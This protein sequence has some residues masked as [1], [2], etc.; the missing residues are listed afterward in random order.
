MIIFTDTD[1]IGSFIIRKFTKSNWSHVAIEHNGM[2]IESLALYRN[3]H[4]KSTDCS[5]DNGASHQLNFLR[6]TRNRECPFCAHK[7]TVPKSQ[8]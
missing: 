5:S 3:N 7:N 1:L 2:V 8:P 6:S 4:H